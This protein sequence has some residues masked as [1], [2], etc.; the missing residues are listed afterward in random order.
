MDF[1]DRVD[2]AQPL[3][4]DFLVYLWWMSEIHED[5]LELPG[6]GLVR[7]WL[8]S[9]LT[10]EEKRMELEQSKLRGAAPSTTPE[11]RVALA[12]AKRPVRA[13]LGVARGSLEWAFTFDA[14][15]FS[16]SGIKLPEELKD[17]SDES[18]LER[19]GLVE[20]LE[21][22]FDALYAEFLGVRLA[23]GWDSAIGEGIRAWVRTGEPPSPDDYA[24]L[25]R[26]A[27]A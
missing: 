10:L 26:R 19:M 27:L 15:A 6:Q 21:A 8:D 25:R 22:I 11:A 4:G 5:G 2:G 20:Q 13:Q 1:L 7:F 16:L 3:G 18:F 14:V 24:A 23:P 12:Q 9:S 17:G